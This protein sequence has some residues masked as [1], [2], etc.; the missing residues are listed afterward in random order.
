MN[1]FFVTCKHF[2]ASTITYSS[3]IHSILA[4]QIEIAMTKK[5]YKKDEEKEVEEL[6]QQKKI[7]SEALRKMLEKLNSNSNKS[8]K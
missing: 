3:F 6:I 8:K 2:V 1:S 5:N 7:E 4:S